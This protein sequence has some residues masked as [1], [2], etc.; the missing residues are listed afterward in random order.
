MKITDERWIL[1]DYH[2]RLIG[3]G[4]PRNRYICFVDDAKDKKRILTYDSEGRARAASEGF[5]HG[6][7]VREYL[8]KVY[9][10]E[11]YYNPKMYPVKV[12][13]TME[14]IE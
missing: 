10:V 9:G 2:H 11:A 12:K 7:G 4:V 3:K 1:M 6:N 13:I 8:E 14:V 5:Y